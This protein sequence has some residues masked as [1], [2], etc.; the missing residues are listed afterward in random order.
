MYIVCRSKYC[1]LPHTPNHYAIKLPPALPHSV[2]SSPL[3][4]SASK[5]LEGNIKQLQPNRA[6]FPTGSFP[7]H[8]FGHGSISLEKCG[9]ITQSDSKDK[10]PQSTS[11]QAAKQKRSRG[12]RKWQ[13]TCFSDDINDLGVSKNNGIPKSSI[14]IRF[15]IINHPFWST[16]I[17]GNTHLFVFLRPCLRLTVV[18]YICF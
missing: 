11:Y 7:T 9:E 6:S 10:S 15:S 16:P 4:A 2:S 1:P 17:F 13:K 18:H 12:H 3:A 8:P 14:F 5:D